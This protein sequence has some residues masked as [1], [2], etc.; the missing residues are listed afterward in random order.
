MK[1]TVYVPGP[2]GLKAP[3][4]RHSRQSAVHV[5]N[6]IIVQDNASNGLAVVQVSNSAATASPT[7][8]S[9]VPMAVHKVP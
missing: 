8:T 5:G 6:A 7:L 3:E 2:G 9:T 1:L 4:D